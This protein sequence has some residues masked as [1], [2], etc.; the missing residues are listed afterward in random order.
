MKA[1]HTLLIAL[2]A[3]AV[4]T[5]AASAASKW[6]FPTTGGTWAIDDANIWS[7]DRA[8]YTS[9]TPPA[10]GD[11]I[12]YSQNPGAPVT[13]T[14]TPDQVTT[15]DSWR[16]ATPVVRSTANP[17]GQWTLQPGDARN[18]TL[19]FTNAMGTLAD[20]RL[21]TGAQIASST[22]DAKLSING[23]TITVFGAPTWFGTGTYG[24]GTFSANIASGDHTIA[25]KTYINAQTASVT[26]GPTNFAYSGAGASQVIGQLAVYE[27]TN[28]SDPNTGGVSFDQ[29]ST[30]NLSQT[31]T[32]IMASEFYTGATA[33]TGTLT[34]SGNTPYANNNYAG[35]LVDNL[36]GGGT[37]V[38][39]LAK[40]GSNTQILS[41]NSNTFSGGTSVTG[42]LLLVNN[43]SGSGL[44]A[45]NV[46]V[47]GTGTLGGTGS[48][49]GAVTVGSGG[50][51]SPGASVESFATGALAMSNGSTF[52][53]EVD[54]GVAVAVGADLQVVSGNLD[55][56]GTVTLTL[57]DLAGSASAFAL[58]TTFS[59][60]NYSGTWNNGLFTYNSNQIADGGTFTAGLNTWRLDYAEATGG[61][62][63]TGD[64]IPG[65]FVNITA[66]PEPATWVLLAAGLTTLVVF[67]RSRVRP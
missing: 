60:I 21:G 6:F 43:T 33:R 22:A 1:T 24:L 40:T 51:L 46:T 15:F 18:V 20:T 47:G 19:T 48:I 62:N 13:I 29:I 14:I 44:G 54:S 49:S 52:A 57:T 8:T 32:T 7:S 39:A 35:R 41:G 9:T 65:S 27:N 10:S 56:S 66:V 38:L 16:S 67:G 50:T 26:G 59:L 42:G 25:G 36:G 28:A 2:L 55:L 31:L 5:G 34:I 3:T 4:S 11:S 64:Y 17:P 61:V 45:G 58:D 53:Y 30:N 23:S 63:F 12:Y 37:M